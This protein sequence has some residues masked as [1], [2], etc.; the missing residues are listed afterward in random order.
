MSARHF[1]SVKPTPGPHQYNNDTLRVKN[2]APHFSMSTRSKSTHELNFDKN[3]YTPAPNT[4]RQSDPYAKKGHVV[5]G[6]SNRKDLTE[7]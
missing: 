4:Y 7:T 2:K 5:I 3:I 1:Q 6:T